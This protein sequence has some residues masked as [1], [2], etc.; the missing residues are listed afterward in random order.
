MKT[1]TNSLPDQGPENFLLNPVLMQ[2]LEGFAL[3]AGAVWA[4]LALGGAWWLIP[5]LFLL[6]D[7]A[8]LGYLGGPK[9]GG[10]LYNLVHSYAVGAAV[11]AA[12]L[13]VQMPLLTFAG[14]LLLLH[15]GAD[16]ALGYGFKL[17]TGFKHTHLGQL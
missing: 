11:L 12:G 17:S 2:R 16:R 13:I 4:W 7:L 15:S 6:P 14:L 10:T 8:M 3:F 9:L 1:N 5:L